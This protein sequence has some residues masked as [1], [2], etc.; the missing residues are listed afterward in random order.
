MTRNIQFATDE[1][2]HILNRGIEGRNIF[3]DKTDY[4]RFL[5]G[6]EKFN[7]SLPV[8][9]RDGIEDKQSYR[10]LPSTKLVDV[11]C[12]CLLPNHFHLLLKQLVDKGIS[13]FMEKLGTGF[14]YYFNVKRQRKGRLFQGSFKAVLINKESQFL[15]ISR[16]QHL[17]ALDLYNPSWREE[18]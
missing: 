11:V 6:L 17:N 7:T 14:A 8:K 18:K 4:Q 13:T 2:Y 12:F 9:L 5:E 1:Y 10:G 15:H 16:Y 3:I